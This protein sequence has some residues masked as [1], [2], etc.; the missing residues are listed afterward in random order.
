MGRKPS[1]KRQDRG[2]RRPK[3]TAP[4]FPTFDNCDPDDP[5][6]FAVPALVGLPGMTGAPL[7]M[8]VKMLRK[9]SRRLWDCGFRY[10]PELRTIRY[11]KPLV[12][13]PN[14]LQNPGTWVPIDEPDDVERK[15]K[16]LTPEQKAAIRKRFHLDDEDRPDPVIPHEDGK[17][18]YLTADG[19][20]ILVTPAQA[21][22]YAA[23]KR[24]AKRARRQDERR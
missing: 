5:D 22:R 18:P 23:A 15:A 2:P 24:D 16:T 11:K 14:W 1:R 20:T 12:G 4:E 21:A 9:V 13:D 7:P 6:N 17:V 10:H 19:R 8:M 3:I